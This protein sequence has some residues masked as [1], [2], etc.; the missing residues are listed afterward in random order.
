M[1]KVNRE[2]HS[3]IIYAVL[4]LGF[5]IGCGNVASE[6]NAPPMQMPEMVAVPGG[7]FEMGYGAAGTASGPVHDV[8]LSAYEIGKY[9]IT[10]DE[11]ASMLNYALVK[12]YLAGEYTNNVTVM[13]R[14]GDSQELIDLDG[15][16]EGKRSQI[17]FS[18]GIFVVEQGMGNRPV[19]YVTWFGAAFYTNM[20][21]EE[22]GLTIYY[23]LTDWQ[24]NLTGGLG[25]RIQTEAEWERAA[26]YADGRAVPWRAYDPGES[27]MD[28]WIALEAQIASGTYANFNG[29]VGDSTD[30]DS[31]ATGVSVL[32]I[33]NMIGNVSEWCQDYYSAYKNEAQTDPVNDSSGVYR[34]RRGGGWLYYANNF[35]WATY[36]TDTNYGFVSYCDLGFRVVKSSA[37]LNAIVF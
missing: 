31:Y 2:K 14:Y 32:G 27:E 29:N 36:H 7:T 8:T 24:L 20:L 25:Y 37:A 22:A 4:L 33:Y 1:L 6:T 18:D 3:L 30:V 23:D 28:M 17:F 15:Y 16:Y 35:Y 12:G 26:R 9:E 5:L 21:N 19:R 34:Q 11:Y 10:N 13:N